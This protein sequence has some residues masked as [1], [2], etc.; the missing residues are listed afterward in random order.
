MAATITTTPASAD[1]PAIRDDS[2]IVLV[3][4]EAFLNVL[5]NDSVKPGAGSLR[6]A[7]IRG[8]GVLPVQGTFP[9]TESPIS[10]GLEIGSAIK[11]SQQVIGGEGRDKKINSDGAD[12]EN[13]DAASEP[14]HRDLVQQGNPSL[15]GF[16]NPTDDRKRVR[17][18]PNPG[19][20]GYDFC[21]Y[22]ACDEENICGEARI[23]LIVVQPDP[24]STNKPTPYPTGA[25]TPKPTLK[26]IQKYTDVTP[27]P[28]KGEKTTP[29]PTAEVKNP[30]PYPTRQTK[31]PTPYPTT[32]NPTS[33]VYY[34]ASA[35]TDPQPYGGTGKWYLRDF[36]QDGQHYYDQYCVRDCEPGG[37]QDNES[38]SQCGGIVQASWVKTFD[39]LDA[40]CAGKLS[41]LDIDLCRSNSNPSKTGSDKYWGGEYFIR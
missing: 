12:Q 28:T 34:S 22:V 6:V 39:S 36:Y 4:K 17:Y 32:P 16:C 7:G 27:Y 14:V 33:S 3:D 35:R 24:Y 40:C 19:F 38:T 2:F 15:N 1:L 13:G 41:W 23:T 21:T 26:A 29:Y 18:M 11:E 5:D 9:L 10:R 37:P 30:T 25:G 31:G 20:T 8:P